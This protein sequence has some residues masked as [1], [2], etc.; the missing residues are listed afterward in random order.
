MLGLQHKIHDTLGNCPF[1][2]L[3]CIRETDY[4]SETRIYMSVVFLQ[5]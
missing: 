2:S 3:V 1:F 4:A 5:A